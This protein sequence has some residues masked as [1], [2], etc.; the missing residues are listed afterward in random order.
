[1][2]LIAFDCVLRCWLSAIRASMQRVSMVLLDLHASES[3]HVLQWA[4]MRNLR[5]G[6]W[7]TLF[8]RLGASA[9]ISWN[10]L[11]DRF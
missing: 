6:L 10:L 7:I 8:L 11:L 4:L 3:G 5:S 1:M 2:P 9:V